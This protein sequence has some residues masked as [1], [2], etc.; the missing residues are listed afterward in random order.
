M[1]CRDCKGEFPGVGQRWHCL[2][3]RS[4]RKKAQDAAS[5]AR[6]RDTSVWCDLPDAVIDQQ[7]TAA[8]AQIRRDKVHRLEAASFDYRN[9]YREP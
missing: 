8:L 7:F 9:R 1:V 2:D 4:K 3:C 5:K 6:Q